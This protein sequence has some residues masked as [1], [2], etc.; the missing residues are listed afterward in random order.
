MLSVVAGPDRLLGGDER[1]LPPAGS[2]DGVIGGSPWQSWARCGPGRRPSSRRVGRRR[3]ALTSRNVWRIPK[4]MDPLLAFFGAMLT[5]LGGV[6]AYFSTSAWRIVGRLEGLGE[7]QGEK[8][9]E[10]G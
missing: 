5:L 3:K 1:D 8:L 10:Q 4:A 9:E 6:G 2:F 7:G